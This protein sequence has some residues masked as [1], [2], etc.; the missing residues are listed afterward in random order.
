MEA[1][2][3]MHVLSLLPLLF[4]KKVFFGFGEA[5]T[6]GNPQTTDSNFVDII[7]TTN[8]PFTSQS[9]Q[10][11]T[12]RDQVCA[13]ALKSG[14]VF[15]AGGVKGSHATPAAPVIVGDVDMWDDNSTQWIP[16][17]PLTVARTNVQCVSAGRIAMFVGGLTDIANYIISDAVDYYIDN[18]EQY[19]WGSA[20][21]SVARENFGIATI[22]NLVV[23]AG[24][25][26]QN[27]LTV[28]NVDIFD[29]VTEVWAYARLSSPRE[30]DPNF[31]NVY[32][33]NDQNVMMLG[34]FIDGTDSEIIDIFDRSTLEGY[35]NAVATNET[36]TA[37]DDLAET[38]TGQVGE[39][40]KAVNMVNDTMYEQL[41]DVITYFEEEI[42]F[43]WDD[44]ARLDDTIAN[45]NQTIYDISDDGFAYTEEQLAFVYA[46]L[47]AQQQLIN[48]LTAKLN[49]INPKCLNSVE[50]GADVSQLC[51]DKPRPDSPDDKT[52]L[53]VAAVLGSIFGVGIAAI[54][55]LWFT[56]RKKHNAL[57]EEHLISLHTP[58]NPKDSS[59]AE[60]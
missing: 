12:A 18:A 7:D 22:G 53:I 48:V 45:I 34:G 49:S 51:P 31:G 15:F 4:G 32:S 1:G 60:L 58:L 14:K 33:V 17:R 55:F 11:T 21:M 41:D 54:V 44:V 8:D 39:L 46:N 27:G 19:S 24:G 23:F 40:Y 10:L 57:L 37:V 50:L 29:S 25:V 42:G 13:T 43:V 56:R 6:P 9:Y 16:Q 28:D 47:T 5:K 35:M 30:F 38:V 52:G 59:L 20:S 36:Y 3:E 26:D 2:L